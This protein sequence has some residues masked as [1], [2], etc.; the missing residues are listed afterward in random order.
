MSHKTFLLTRASG[1]ETNAAQFSSLA[2]M[3]AS[4]A[5]AKS[6]FTLLV[7]K[8]DGAIRDY[9]VLDEKAVP[10]NAHVTLSQ[11]LG[12][13]PVE[14]QLP[15]HI[16]QATV[17]GHSTYVSAATSRDTQHGVENA[18]FARAIAPVIGEGEWIAVTARAATKKESAAH[19]KWL[20]H[21]MGTSRPTHHSM[22]TSMKDPPR[23][24]GGKS[25]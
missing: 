4:A 23:T 1:A 19:V 21:R 24:P 13:A 9:L 15:D 11:A 7:T 6:S 14:A 3:F 22:T 12:A 16:D 5:T 17:L 2:G 10:G 8:E 18:D 20:S 25:F